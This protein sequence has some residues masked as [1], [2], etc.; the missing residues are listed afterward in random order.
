M[1]TTIPETG[2]NYK[3]EENF[4][5]ED[6]YKELKIFLCGNKINWFYR[7][8]E[9][10]DMDK[11]LTIGYFS[12]GWYNNW[13]PDHPLFFSQ[14]VPILNKLNC[15][16]P[17]QIRANLTFNRNI[18]CS[19]SEWH[20]DYAYKNS[21]TAIIYFTT[22]NASTLLNINNKIITVNSLE[23]RLLLFNS[24]IEHKVVYGDDMNKRIV[25][26]LNFF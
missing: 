17:L 23:N 5:P 13:Q 19:G 11:N 15:K 12:F 16:A 21:F 2:L 22:C 18:T 6:L 8:K 7:E 20:I 9:T 14:I 24:P 1:V 4:L 3:I 26:N 10:S 25:M